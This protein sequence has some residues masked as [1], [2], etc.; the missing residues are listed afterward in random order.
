MASSK[1]P[2]EPIPSPAE[3]H[4]RLDRLR[5]EIRHHERLYYDLGRPEISDAE[6]DA[7]MRELLRIEERHPDLITP[8]SPSLRVGGGAPREGVER[9]R[10]SSAMLSLDN[11]FDEAE[12]RDFDRRA[13]KLAEV[14]ELD[15]VGELKLDGVSMVVRFVAGLLDLALTRGDGEH[16]EIVT[17]NARTLRSVPLS[18]GSDVL[19][20]ANVP[21]DFEV[22]GEV[23][24]PK[25]AFAQLNRRQRD[26]GEAMY[27][28][29]R[30]AAAGAL[31][32][33]DAKVTA[34]RRLDFYPY[35]LLGQGQPIFDTH[36]ESLEALETLRFKVD[37]RRKRLRGIDRLLEFRNEWMARREE[38]PYEIDGLVFKVDATALQQ[39]LGA[40][41][42]APRWAIASKLAAQQAETV[43]EDID[44]Q[45]GRTGAVTP[46]ARLRPVLVGGVTVSR[47]TLHNED[48][49]VRLGLQV[50]D[51]VLIERS[52]DVIPKV[53]RVIA[54]GDDR[55]SFRMPSHCPECGS[56]VEREQGEVVAR[57]INVDCRAR[58]K[59]SILHFAHRAAMDIDGLGEWLVD[60][61][62]GRDGDGPVTDLA[63]LYKLKPGHLEGIEKRSILGEIRARKL[64]ESIARSKGEATLAR[65][66][67]ALNVPGIGIRTIE[68]LGRQYSSLSDIA[69]ASV[70]DLKQV[71][72][73]RRR[74]AESITEFF[75][76]P[77]IGTLID[78]LDPLEP[79]RAPELPD[80]VSSD[81]AQAQPKATAPAS[82]GAKLDDETLKVLL[83]RLTAPV[84]L[85]NG[86]KLAGS[87]GGVGKVL[88]GK[89]VE[90][91]LVRCPMDLYRLDVDDLADIPTATRL[92]RKSAE[93]VISSLDRSKSAPL[94][95][96]VYGL[97]IRHVGERTAELLAERF[98]SL[99]QLAQ[100]A[101]EE[102]E[103][104]DEVGPRIAD[105]VLQFFS[106]ERNKAL[107]D[108]LRDSGLRFEE[109]GSEDGV[110][111]SGAETDPLAG[112]VFVLTGTLSHMTREEARARI[113]AL[114]GKVTSTVS[115]KTDY[116]VVG[117]NPG[118][119]LDKARELQVEVLNEKGLFEKLSSGTEM[120]LS[121]AAHDGLLEG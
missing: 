51:T 22:R 73:V 77:E 116:V 4:G 99:D 103:D 40:T 23:V 3:A 61:L 71:K 69:S 70:D 48:E 121:E 59:E 29:P 39:R 16:G 101:K 26:K 86:E 98:R 97:G 95:R 57:C 44:V 7:L 119:K 81:D 32:M 88:A 92:G 78:A 35:L 68:A 80:G 60:A 25:H 56:K 45:V 13:C 65:K 43:V 10:H 84:R 42:K 67:Y 96:L 76:R 66:L 37:S 8:D 50:G 24:M 11:A 105:S 33:L 83:E 118:S 1:P 102:L 2:P 63:G 36:W 72:G 30:N 79:P 107:I 53:V 113:R 93:T 85:E 28:S 114:G 87:V 108:N 54:R 62:L 21:P 94:A 38:L 18:I 12:L 58:L 52:G 106:S 41:S 111:A 90:R 31:R 91:R 34:S 5:R 15:Y 55:T 82:Q 117:D 64:I 27:A 47:A 75:R 9:A 20:T 115:G 46:R 89:L 120:P 74:D 19:E 6:F 100:A 110:A 14:D 112:R 109:E 17:P 104:V 49:I